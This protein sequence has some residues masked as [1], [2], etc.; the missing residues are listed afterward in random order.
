M[1]QKLDLL[2][3]NPGAKKE[4][5]GK[6][7]SSLSGIEP[8]IW[9]GLIAAYIREKGY[10]VKIIDA[11]A[12]DLSPEMTAKKI[13]EHNPLLAGIIV[14]GSNP[15][16]SS[17][18]KMTSTGKLLS[19]LNKNSPHIK[20]ILGGLHPSALPERT[21]KEEKTDFVCQGEGF[22]TILEL[23]ETLKSNKETDDYRINGL[24]YAKNG[25]VAS[26]PVAPLI[27]DIDKLPFA[28]WDLLPMEKYRAHNWHCFDH[29]D[30]R[31]NYAVIYTSLG[32][33]FNC[34]YCN[35]H[36]LYG[37][38][39]GI[40]FRTPE[41]VV[42]EID[43]LVKNYKIMNMKILDELFALKEDRVL[44][45]CDLII[46][47]GYD[48]NIWAY[49]R[50]DT[51]TEKMLK[52]MKEAGI[53]WLAYGFE[54]ASTKVRRGVSKKFEQEQI[55]R[56]VEMTQNA[57]I[58]IIGN[59][60]F[61]LPDDDLETMRETLNMTKEFNFEYVNFYTAM[62]YPGSQLYTDALQAGINLPENWHGYSQYG[63]ET[64]PMLT[65]HLSASQVLNFRDKAFEE[66]FCNPKYL[67]MIRKKF[68]H[69]IVQHIEEM[70]KYKIHR[71]FS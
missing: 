36:T 29:I 11:E 10:S 58:Y 57:G 5:Y 54:S 39:P 37:G 6:L 26:N 23:L 3:V 35:I 69:K 47:G 44:R 60:I 7:S 28:A 42:E 9:C 16:A 17:T 43:F 46:D 2:L 32:C 62:A 4:V 70:L 19:V 15:S 49:A 30:Q 55:K 18:P 65:K 63:E 12:E 40:R 56:A 21:L 1:A 48:L 66:Y 14:L 53:S 24:W 50:V 20:T 33:P 51:I 61:G 27:E 31:G 41:K 13:A 8:P 45:I 34:R 52:K 38:K 22:H 59:I 71:K 68:G 64:L 67:E 25:K